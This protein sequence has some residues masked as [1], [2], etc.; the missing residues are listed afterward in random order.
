MRAAI[1]ARVSTAR[2][3]DNTS[4]PNQLE[5]TREYIEAQG[6]EMAA[7]FVEPG[8]SGENLNRPAMSA[9]RQ[10]TQR[11]EFDVLVV[12]TLDRLT[13]D[14]DDLFLLRRE[15]TSASVAIRAVQE[16]LDVTTAD[17]DDLLGVLFKGYFGHRELATIRRRTM[18]GIERHV[19]A[20]KFAG[21]VPPFGY[22]RG[23]DGCLAVSEPEARI[24]AMMFDWAAQRVSTRQIA[25][26]MD[27][28][29]IPSPQAQRGHKT[30]RR[31]DGTQGLPKGWTPATVRLILRSEV[32]TGRWTYGK[33]NPDRANITVD[34]PSLVDR[35]TWESAQE[36]LDTNRRYSR[37]AQYC[38]LLRGL[39]H[40]ECGA[41]F[42]GIKPRREGGH[43]S[44]RCLARYDYRKL[45]RSQCQ[46]V[47]IRGDELE[48]AIWADVEMF[49]GQPH[50]VAEELSKRR[51]PVGE[52]VAAWL[53]EV[54]RT[55][56]ERKAELDRYLALYGRG[57]IPI[58]QL[59][60]KAEETRGFLAG[61]ELYRSGLVEEQRR[62]DLWE[63]EMVSIVGALIALQ[64]RLDGSLTWE[65]KRAVIEALVK[66]V[67]IETH[68]NDA[69]EQYPVAHVT[70]RFERPDV[71][72]A[73]IPIELAPLFA[74]V[75][76]VELAE[77]WQ[78]LQL[79]L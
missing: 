26:R 46:S 49:V 51:E 61:L 62:A 74:N 9:A 59:D 33:K 54:D 5:R 22:R 68:T 71:T 35:A 73:P 4:I 11:G 56:G 67:R 7:T 21:G 13:R 42:C 75:E 47:T 25:Q 50:L 29:E 32:Y 64:E 44:Y 63:R 57:S 3:A 60:A 41:A 72:E 31:K 69:G 20:G 28:L 70:Y 12:Y 23:D 37:P 76:L 36:A 18:E 1:Y 27:A 10:A 40:C 52:T 43:H 77:K 6:W 39:I 16:G 15:F 65:D 66:G 58:E 45:H 2:Q 53:V 17:V 8:E 78:S 48:A 55:I 34:V 24:V 19:E 38:Y 30:R 14:L 79:G